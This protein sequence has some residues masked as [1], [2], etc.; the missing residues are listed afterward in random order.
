MK[1]NEADYESRGTSG[2]HSWAEETVG[3]HRSVMMVL[4]CFLLSFDNG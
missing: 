2:S 3:H 1:S 4:M